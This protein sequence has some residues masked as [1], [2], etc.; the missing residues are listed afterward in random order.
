[1]RRC[2]VGGRNCPMSSAARCPRL[3]KTGDSRTQRF[4]GRMRS[5]RRYL[6]RSLSLMA[7]CLGIA[8]ARPRSIASRWRLW[9]LSHRLA[10]LDQPPNESKRCDPRLSWHSAVSAAPPNGCFVRP[11]LVTD[12]FI[13]RITM[14]PEYLTDESSEPSV[15]RVWA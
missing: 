7:G 14:T 8:S 13:L 5:G 10:P 15:I 9:R 3:A 12:A 1:V 11:V 2:E 6:R 4:T